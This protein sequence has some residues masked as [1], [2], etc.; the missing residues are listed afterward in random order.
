M[1]YFEVFLS[2]KAYA[3]E[4]RKSCELTLLPIAVIK[5]KEQTVI[6]ESGLK[7]IIIITI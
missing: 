4:Q 5:S 2:T 7:I 3:L 6:R 1:L